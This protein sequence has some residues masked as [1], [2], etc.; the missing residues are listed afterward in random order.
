MKIPAPFLFWAWGL[1]LGVWGLG[2]GL[3]PTLIF[4]ISTEGRMGPSGEICAGPEAKRF[5]KLPADPS[6]RSPHSLGR[7]DTTGKR[8]SDPVNGLVATTPARH[9]ITAAVYWFPSLYVVLCRCWLSPESCLCRSPLK[10]RE[11]GRGKTPYDVQNK[12]GLTAAI[13]FV[14]DVGAGFIPALLRRTSH[15]E[16][17][18]YSEAR[19]LS[20]REPSEV[21]IS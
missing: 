2:L 21:Q 4:V 3:P 10:D 1:G 5:R 17:S 16:E 15:L 9:L 19:T 7:D 13:A 14:R 11:G 8:F 12:N 18:A 6:T 20:T